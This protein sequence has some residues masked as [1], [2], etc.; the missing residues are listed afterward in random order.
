[1]KKYIKPEF[2]FTQFSIEDVITES[3]VI[4]SADSLVGE[5]KDMYE[6]YSQSSAVQ[7]KSVSV[8]TW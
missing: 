7:N 8:F 3:G 1:M 2:N 4:V 6:I 5:N